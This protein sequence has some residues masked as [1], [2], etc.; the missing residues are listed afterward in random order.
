VLLLCPGYIRY[1]EIMAQAPEEFKEFAG[2]LDNYGCG[3]GVQHT[4]RKADGGPCMQLAL[5]N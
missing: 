1:K 5:S 4:I 3:G 2:C